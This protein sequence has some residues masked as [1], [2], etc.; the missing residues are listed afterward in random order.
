MIV[1][2]KSQNHEYPD[3]L[4]G[5]PYSVI[6]I[7]ANDYRLLND[8]GKPYLY[9]AD[10]FNVID[11]HEP[12]DWVTET[13]D[14]GERYSYPELLNDVGFFEDF[15]DHKNDQIKIFRHVVNQRLFEAA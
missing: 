10:I 8:S 9:P 1:K 11:S 6:G 7:E 5:Q 2:L 13:G 3:L 15:F 4:E 14:D 12:L